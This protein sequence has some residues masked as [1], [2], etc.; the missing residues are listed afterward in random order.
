[1]QKHPS[2]GSVSEGIWCSCEHPEIA[3]HQCFL[4]H[5]YF[6][7]LTLLSHVRTQQSFLALRL[8]SRV[9]VGFRLAFCLVVVDLN[10]MNILIKPL[11]ELFFRGLKKVTPIVSGGYAFILLG[12]RLQLHTSPSLVY[13][14][15]NRQAVEAHRAEPARLGLHPYCSVPLLEDARP[16]Q[17]PR[18][19]LFPSSLST[20]LSQC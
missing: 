3:F 20:L 13:T 14:T 11:W 9:W 8:R 17:Q 16:S 18:P 4:C 10:F 12:F 15:Y 19:L 1:M 6:Y 7:P 2:V 5:W